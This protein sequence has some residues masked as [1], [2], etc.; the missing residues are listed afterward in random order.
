MM[1]GGDGSALISVFL[2]LER[3]G[4]QKRTGGGRRGGLWVCFTNRIGDE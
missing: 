3:G 2:R 1:G 4:T